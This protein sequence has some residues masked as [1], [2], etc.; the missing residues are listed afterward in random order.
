LRQLKF[1]PTARSKSADGDGYI[2]T[3]YALSR[4]HSDDCGTKNDWKGTYDLCLHYIGS[5]DAYVFAP[6]TPKR[7]LQNSYHTQNH[8]GAENIIV[9]GFLWAVDYGV[10]NPCQRIHAFHLHC[11]GERHYS[12][13]SFISKGQH[14]RMQNVIPSGS[15][16]DNWM[17]ILI[18]TFR[19]RHIYFSLQHN[20]FVGG[21]LELV[22][23]LILLD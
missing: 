5:H 8:F 13:G 2:R 14:G 23:T 15:A 9:W 16:Q 20:L 12:V 1:G 17:Y 10:F 7:V 19:Q 6:S 4:R 18:T 22:Q 11:S 21:T 3:A